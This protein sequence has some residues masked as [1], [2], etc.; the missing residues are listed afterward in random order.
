MIRMPAQMEKWR[1]T[2]NSV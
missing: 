1:S 2:C